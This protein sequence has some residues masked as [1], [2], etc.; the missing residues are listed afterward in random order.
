MNPSD[1]VDRPWYDP[2]PGNGRSLSGH[3]CEGEGSHSHTKN[4]VSNTAFTKCHE[5]NLQRQAFI[6]V[7]GSQGL[8]MDDFDRWSICSILA[9]AMIVWSCLQPPWFLPTFSW[10]AKSN[11]NSFVAMGNFPLIVIH[12]VYVPICRFPKMGMTPKLVII[13]YYMLYQW[14]NPWFAV[15]IF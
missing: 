7:F 6:E 3:R 8:C 12:I 15:P 5:L 10:F 14:E 4:F 1:S 11:A 2:V 13:S 9:P